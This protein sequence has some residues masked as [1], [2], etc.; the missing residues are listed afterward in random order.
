[1][2]H[3]MSTGYIILYVPRCICGCRNAAD[4]EIRAAFLHIV[5]IFRACQRFRFV[6]ALSL[7]YDAADPNEVIE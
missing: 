1:M 7:K 2:P 6:V 4:S 5:G 3:R